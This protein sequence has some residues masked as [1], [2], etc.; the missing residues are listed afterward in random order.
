MPVDT[1]SPNG[2]ADPG[3]GPQRREIP[4]GG[5]PRVL[6]ADQRVERGGLGGVVVRG[7]ERHGDDGHGE[8]GQDQD[9]D[10]EQQIVGIE[11]GGDRRA[12]TVAVPV[13]RHRSTVRLSG[14]AVDDE[15]GADDALFI[16]AGVPHSYDVIEG[17]FEFLCIVPNAPDRIMLQEPGC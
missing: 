1:A 8:D 4:G 14:I 5:G 6:G 9:R 15:V 17:P 7:E 11:A 12:K 3:T 16:P 10:G 13:R 2:N